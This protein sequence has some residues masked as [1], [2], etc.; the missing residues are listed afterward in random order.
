MKKF[1]LFVFAGI[2]QAS[3]ARA[4]DLPPKAHPDSSKWQDLIAPDLSNADFTAGVWYIEN[5]AFTANKDETIWSKKDWENFCIDLEFQPDENANSGVVI[6]CTDTKNWIPNSVE[7]QILDDSGSKWKSANPTW[8]CGAIF[9]RLAAS[10]SMV[11]KP[12]EWN[13]MTIWAKGQMIYVML[14]GE[15]VTECDM[16]K[17][18]DGKKN[19]DGTAIPSWLPK[20]LATLPTK[21]RIGLQGKHGGAL[22]HFRNVKIKQLD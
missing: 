4:E 19:P 15:L 2:V 14:N 21:G 1:M 9:G 17:W 3:L 5:G 11:R 12:G 6:Y 20:P 7:V 16:S 13:R 8:K 10:K 18:T 22:I